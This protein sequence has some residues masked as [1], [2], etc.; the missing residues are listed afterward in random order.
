MRKINPDK[1]KTYSFLAALGFLSSLIVQKG[2]GGQEFLGSFLLCIVLLL[3]LYKDILR[4]KPHYLQKR[5]MLALLG[6]MIIST[7]ALG[8]LTEFTLEGLTKGLEIEAG[9]TVIFGIPVPAGAMLVTL[10]FD[11]HTAIV[12]SFVVSLLSGAWQGD[13]AFTVYAFVGSLTAAFSMIRCKKRTAILKGGLY[14]LGVNLLT[15]ITLLLFNGQFI[16]QEAPLAMAFTAFSALFMVAIVSL[17]LPVLE[18]VFKAT[19]DI[20]LLELMDLEHPLMKNLMISAPGTYHHSI[21]LGNLV[22]SCAEDIGVNPLLARVGAYYHDI[23][24]IKMP[25]YFIENQSSGVSKHETLTPHMSSMILISHVKEGVELAEQHKLPEAVKE[26][27]QQHHGCALITYFYERAKGQSNGEELPVDEYKYPGPRPQSRIAALIMLAD[28]VEAASRVLTDPTPSR[29]AS[30]VD[31]IINHIFLDGQLDECE[32]SLKD[33]Y[34]IRK[35]FTYILTGI[36]HKRIDY[37]GFDF[38]E[39]TKDEG[40]NKQSTKENKAGHAQ[41][42]E[43]FPA[44]AG[45]AGTSKGRT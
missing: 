41:D 25:E 37:P 14:V 11:F 42:K 21:I 27:I 33:I 28:A 30:L 9:R 20:T 43:G 16:T 40:N 36:L 2:E 5:S 34:E 29:I 26:I 18:Y 7:L 1:L 44:G 31:K 39:E 12:F 6:F 45:V 17:A 15:V 8:W 19:T 4:Y 23:G 10:L 22:E 32:L 24:K 35:R 3:I 13:A 38:N